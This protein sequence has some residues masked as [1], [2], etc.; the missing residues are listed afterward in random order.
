MEEVN[1]KK[2]RMLVD[3]A[4]AE[5]ITHSGDLAAMYAYVGLESQGGYQH[6]AVKDILYEK[7]RESFTSGHATAQQACRKL[8][9]DLIREHVIMDAPLDPYFEVLCHLSDALRVANHD[10][11]EI[12]G[13]WSTAV[14]A[15]LD[16]IAIS[17]LNTDNREHVYARDFAVAKAA[18]A[19]KNIGYAI[20]LESDWISLEESA[21]RA[22]VKEIE[23]LIAKIGGLNVLRRLFASISRT[24]DVSLQR[25]HLIPKVS[26]TERAS[27]QVPWG[28][29]LQLAVKHVFGKKPFADTDDNWKQLCGLITAYAAVIDVQPY[30]PNAFF[31]FHPQGLLQHIQETAIYDTM[32]RLPQLRPSDVVRLCKGVLG[33]QDPTVPTINGWSIDQALEIIAAIF[34]LTPDVR[35]PFIIAGADL[36]RSLPHISAPILHRVLK[37]VLSHSTT[38]ANQNFSLPTD[39]PTSEDKS[40]GVNFLFRP[41]IQMP[42]NRFLIIDRSVCAAAFP[43]ALFTA[44][45]ALDT[46]FDDKVGKQIERFLEAEFKNHGVPVHGGDYDVN[47]EHGECDIVAETPEKVVFI[48]LKKKPL[49]RNAKAGQDAYLILDLAGSLLAAQAQ[50]GWHELRLRRHGHLELTNSE[51]PYKLDLNGREVERI[52]VSLL[53]FGSFQD[54]V[55]LR[56]L[57]ETTLS[58]GFSPLDP[59]LTRRFEKINETLDEIRKQNSEIHQGKDNIAQPFF[60]CWFLSLPQLLILLDDVTDMTSFWSELVRTRHITTGSADFYYELSYMR[61]MKVNSPIQNTTN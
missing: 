43:E 13:N 19:L 48:E 27:P 22:L 14:K 20:R 46:D 12:I 4:P 33:F 36:Q 32:F 26:M 5:I 52:A 55:F 37:Q 28:Y 10:Q 15:T 45:R 1:L 38:G 49:T 25:Y 31:S 30:I 60:H 3:E 54:R 42:R 29:M 61:G 9:K 23:Q 6:S 47:G 53:D 40:Q 2:F 34:H 44:L 57:L 56:H 18:R 21:E 8:L 58:S 59:E 16:H 7:V 35:G 41:L 50:A 11:K 51:E 24:Y 39:A 17:D